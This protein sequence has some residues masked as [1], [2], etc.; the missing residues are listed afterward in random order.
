MR[1]R[2]IFRP[3]TWI[4]TRITPLA[5]VPGPTSF[6]PP[7]TPTTHAS[8]TITCGT[9]D[10]HVICTICAICAICV[11]CVTCTSTALV[12][13]YTVFAAVI[14][15]MA[16]KIATAAKYTCLVEIDPISTNFNHLP[17]QVLRE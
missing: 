12:F 17:R 16:V 6:S 3:S 14:D 10:T 9:R 5:R 13:P 7:T 4:A 11:T 1:P 2:T 8:H 15:A